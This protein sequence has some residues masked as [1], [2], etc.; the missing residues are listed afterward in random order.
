MESIP[1]AQYVDF[2]KPSKM[3]C[4]LD[5]K[6]SLD[7]NCEHFRSCFVTSKTSYTATSGVTVALTGA[8]PPPLERFCSS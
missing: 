6:L 8:S 2:S 1:Q 5:S 4:F 7:R 3:K